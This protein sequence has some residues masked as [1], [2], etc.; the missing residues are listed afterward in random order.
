MN[1]GVGSFESKKNQT[2]ESAVGQDLQ[3]FSPYVIT[4]AALSSQL[5]KTMIVGPAGV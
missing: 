2:C 1:S 4:K 5:F 3:Y